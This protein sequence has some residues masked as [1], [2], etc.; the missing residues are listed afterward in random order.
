MSDVAKLYWFERHRGLSHDR[1]V[2]VVAGSF[3]LD[4]ATVKRQLGFD[5][6]HRRAQ[7]HT[8]SSE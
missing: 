4:Q 8:R 2:S 1:A 7:A 6:R 3:G 5:E